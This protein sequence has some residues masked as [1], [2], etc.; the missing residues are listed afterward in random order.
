MIFK[1]V[2]HNELSYMLEFMYRGE[3]GVKHEELPSFLKLAES[4]KI[5]GLNGDKVEVSLYRVLI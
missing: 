2:G 3:V 1:D 5:K 4:L